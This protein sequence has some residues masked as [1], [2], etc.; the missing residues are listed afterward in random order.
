MPS[1]LTAVR[2][3]DRARQIS[4]VLV[5]HG[6]GEV[7]ARIG[8]G[9]GE[10]AEKTEGGTDAVDSSR[11]TLAERLR[12]VLQELGPSF[13]KL[14]QI[15]STRPDI[16]PE[17]VITELK[18]LQDSVPPFDG[19]EARSIIESQLGA[20]I[21]EVFSVFDEKPLAS[22]SIAQVHRAK[23]KTPEGDAD[24]AI[25]VQ[26]P[27]IRNTIERDIDLLYWFAHAV[28]R[29]IPE[30]KTYNPVELVR[31]FDR[32]I[33][34]ELDFV[35]EAENAERFAKNFEGNPHVKFPAVYRAASG[36]RVLTL[37]FLD[38]RK[39]E[40]ALAEGVDG[41]LLAHHAV[42]LVINMIF[43][44]GFFHADPHPG[45][46]LILGTNEAPVIG[47]LDLGLVG[48]LSPAM[49]DR[50]IDMMVAAVREDMDGLADALH[51]IGKPSR[52]VDQMAF[53]ADVTMLSRKYLGKSIK[54]IEMAGLIS[55][56]V[57][58]AIRHGI[59]M[60]P[61]FLM[62]G[63][64][65]MTIEGIGRQL[66]PDLDVFNEMKPHFLRLL[67]KRYSP[68]KI[69][70]D[71]LKGFVR[72]S[73]MAGNMPEQ[74]A[75]ILEDLRK[76]HLLVK[77]TD[78]SLPMITERLGRQLYTGLVVGSM[79]FGGAIIAAAG[80]HPWVGYVMIGF[81]A[82]VAGWHALRTWWTGL[83]MRRP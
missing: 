70:A 51:A 19:A 58:G 63:K 53:R 36:K 43:D 74:L 31:E 45:N 47:M 15:V 37:E 26:R 22:A 7:A 57:T 41:K 14:G 38:G 73:G 33:T 66:D 30:S 8:F 62:V 52:K 48:H 23:L 67:A 21:E 9:G 42:E 76:G 59:D 17:D 79:V 12:L 60:P 46:I 24:V 20:P 27:N 1:L 32:S 40:R 25:K 64:S 80:K 61:D 6:F 81:A 34:A 4:F 10:K 18:K 28:E 72:V 29:A 71:L 77:T 75:E 3:L 83:Q 54:E 44:H 50:A 35:Q 69:G 16:I 11:G 55:D 5:K 56:L 49:R 78:P 39:I 13:V 68:D 82:A 65:L 2:D